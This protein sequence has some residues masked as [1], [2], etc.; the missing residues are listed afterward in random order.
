MHTETGW[1]EKLDGYM[2]GLDFC[3]IRLPIHFER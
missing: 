2:P 1:I 3:M